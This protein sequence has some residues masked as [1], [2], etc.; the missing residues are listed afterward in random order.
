MVLPPF[1][2]EKNHVEDT[3]NNIY[4]PLFS[5]QR[6]ING[7]LRTYSLNQNSVIRSKSKKKLFHV[8][9]TPYRTDLYTYTIADVKLKIGNTACDDSY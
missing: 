3:L 1:S 4:T 5:A 6:Y 8:L 2:I 9:N 7:N